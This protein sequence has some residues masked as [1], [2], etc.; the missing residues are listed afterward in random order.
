MVAF[1]LQIC[2]LKSRLT[3]DKVEKRGVVSLHYKEEDLL[4]WDIKQRWADDNMAGI[5]PDAIANK[6]RVP[7]DGRNGSNLVA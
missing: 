5:T 6:I 3:Q 7:W 2:R 1:A 4:V